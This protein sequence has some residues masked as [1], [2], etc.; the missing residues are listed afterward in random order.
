MERVDFYGIFNSFSPL[1]CFGT[2]LH[3]LS[4]FGCWVGK[5]SLFALIVKKV[6]HAFQGPYKPLS[7]PN[8]HFLDTRIAVS[9]PQHLLPL[10]HPPIPKTQNPP[11]FPAYK[12]VPFI[13]YNKFGGMTDFSTILNNLLSPEGQTRQTAEDMLTQHVTQDPV[14]TLYAMI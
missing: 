14:N 12:A 1:G 6:L 8:F 5:I 2:I 4:D 9:P 10:S 13:H 11:F 3:V 7:A